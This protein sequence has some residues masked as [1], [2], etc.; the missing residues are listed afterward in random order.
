MDD[1]VR[2]AL[3]K[4][5]NVPACYG[6]LAL[7]ARGEWYMRDE[8]VQAAGAVSGRQGQPHQPREAARVHP[9]QLRGRR[10]GML[11]LPERAAARLRRARSRALG[12]AA[13]GAGRRAARCDAH[14]GASGTGGDELA[15]RARPALPRHR[16]RPRHRAHAGHA[17]G[18]GGGRERR[19]GAAAPSR[20]PSCRRASA[21]GCSPTRRAMTKA[22]A[23][24]GSA[25]RWEPAY[26]AG[27][28]A[29]ATVAGA[30]AAAAGALGSSNFAPPLFAR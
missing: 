27:A 21:T 11:V 6:W 1:I 17:A 13:A 24:A 4:W 28:D 9:P 5:P 7:D 19:V 12:V 22:G 23:C 26:L 30:E 10:G 3:K 29:A 15:R 18:R 8:R 2:A 20:S 16:P 14:T 25:A